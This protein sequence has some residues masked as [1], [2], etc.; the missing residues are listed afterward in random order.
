M[1]NYKKYAYQVNIFL[2]EIKHNGILLIFTVQKKKQSRRCSKL[3][4]QT[5]PR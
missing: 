3:P 1:Q 5:T 4:A 2:K